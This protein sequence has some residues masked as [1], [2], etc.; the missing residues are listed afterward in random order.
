MKPAKTR[1]APDLTNHHIRGDVKKVLFL[2]AQPLRGKKI[3][4]EA[5]YKCPQK[6]VATKLEGGG[7]VAFVSGP[8]KTFFEASLI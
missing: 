4:F 6:N 1:D 3:L 2:E 7:G 8:L 5:L